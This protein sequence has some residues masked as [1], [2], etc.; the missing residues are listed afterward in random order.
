MKLS[1]LSYLINYEWFSYLK[2][3]SE[4]ENE[5]KD[6]EKDEERWKLPIVIHN[7]KNH[8]LLVHMLNEYKNFR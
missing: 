2:H 4:Y 8:V 6:G 1:F 3:E 5:Y 7:L